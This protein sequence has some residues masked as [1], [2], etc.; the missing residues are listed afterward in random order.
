MRASFDI[1]YPCNWH[2]DRKSS[3]TLPTLHCTFFHARNR[4][5]PPGSV[6]TFSAQFKEVASLICSACVL[7][8]RKTEMLPC[9][10]QLKPDPVWKLQVC[11]VG[12]QGFEISLLA[13]ASVPVSHFIGEPLTPPFSTEHVIYQ[14]LRSTW[15]SAPATVTY[16]HF[17]P[18]LPSLPDLFS[19][20]LLPHQFP[21]TCIN[22]YHSLI[23][24]KKSSKV[25]GSAASTIYSTCWFFVPWVK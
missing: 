9:F 22:S 21:L 25:L 19:P 10:L 15:Q 17:L 6:H 3:I 18:S 2:F 13:R 1:S 24:T 4:P 23:V 11:F 7:S 16:R 12:P 8:G 5:C 20:P 14:P